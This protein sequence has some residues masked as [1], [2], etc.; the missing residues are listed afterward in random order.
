MRSILAAV[1]V[2]LGAVGAKF[3]YS[4]DHSVISLI[5]TCA[6]WTATGAAWAN[7]LS[8]RRMQRGRQIR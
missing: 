7:V 3:A 4:S 8:A 5:F 2:L 6:L 1:G